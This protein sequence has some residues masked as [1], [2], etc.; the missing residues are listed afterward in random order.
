MDQRPPLSIKLRRIWELYSKL[1][2]LASLGERKLKIPVQKFF[3]VQS[4]S[5]LLLQGA[6]FPRL[7]FYASL[8]AE[9][10]IQT[11]FSPLS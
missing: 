2:Q 9:G 11:C 5:H 4:F 8:F 6:L 7:L 3:H 1:L 10:S